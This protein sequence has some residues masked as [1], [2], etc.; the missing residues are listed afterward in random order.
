MWDD[1]AERRS[2]SCARG[3]A[4]SF[5]GTRLEQRAAGRTQTETPLSLAVTAAWPPVLM[6]FLLIGSE[7]KAG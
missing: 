4:S 5:I 6:P 3:Y 1:G 7:G 2:P